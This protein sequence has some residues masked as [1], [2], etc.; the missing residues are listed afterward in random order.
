MKARLLSMILM[1]LG[2]LALAV[3][4][5]AGES[6]GPTSAWSTVPAKPD[7]SLRDP[8]R[9]RGQEVFRARCLICHG[10]IPKEVVAGGIPPM[11]GTQALQARYQGKKP[12]LL[13][14]RTD[15]TP[16]YITLI[17]RK[18]INSMPFF[19]PTE[20]TNTDLKAVAAY[21]SHNRK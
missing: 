20:I 11:P 3:N 4:V 1:L 19:R 10:P 13:E 8:Q 15:L 6:A 7:T 17:V 2:M 12:A 14:Q 21:L 18:G 9:R 16:D 5:F